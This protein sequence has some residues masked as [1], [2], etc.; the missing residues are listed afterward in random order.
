MTPG[1]SQRY[2]YFFGTAEFDEAQFELRVGGAAVRVERKPLELLLLLLRSGGQV[3]TRDELRE[4]LWPRVDPVDYVLAN[5]VR[6]LRLAL[7]VG[8]QDLILTQPRVG[9]RLAL[10]PRR[11]AVG[12]SQAPQSSAALRVTIQDAHARLHETSKAIVEGQLAVEAAMQAGG[13]LSSLALDARLQL[14]ADLAQGSRFA[15][16]EALLQ[17]VEADLLADTEARPLARA[18]LWWVRSDLQAYRLEL[19]PS[20]ASAEKAYALVTQAPDADGRLAD[21]IATRLGIARRMSGDYQGSERVFRALIASYEARGL[22]DTE[23][24][25]RSKVSLSRCLAFQWR[26]GEALDLARD[27]LDKLSTLFG[28]DNL[29]TQTAHDGVASVLFKMGEYAAAAEAWL[30]VASVLRGL[31][32]SPTDFCIT[33]RSNV[34]LSWL[35]AGRPAEA[36]VAARAALEMAAP[37]F[38]PESPRVQ[39]IRYQLAFS[40]LDQGKA[41]GVAGLLDGLDPA[42]LQQANHADDWAG[43]LAYQQGRLAFLQGRFV[44]ARALFQ[45]AEHVLAGQRAEPALSPVNLPLVQSWLARTRDA[46]RGAGR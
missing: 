20:L 14:A 46:L 3:V 28:R 45:Q 38:A 30:E 9:Y 2:R 25:Q 11:L 17:Q 34:G 15:E 41:E 44:E 13:P 27:A 16:C 21:G 39:S 10:Q 4:R 12:L 6:K 33:A 36:E 18:R 29:V 19:E 24:M 35:Y 40:L 26:T 37:L 22:T 5:A 43:R 8:N 31:T 7:G 23:G 1:D 42:V 32:P